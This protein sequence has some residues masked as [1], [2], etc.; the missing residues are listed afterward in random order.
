MAQA[1]PRE[2]PAVALRSHINHLRAL[3]AAATLALVGLT[4]AVAILATDGERDISGSS[5]NPLCALTPKERHR[6]QA[7]RS[8]SPGQP[9]AAFGRRIVPTPPRGTPYDGDPG[10]FGPPP[11]TPY[12]GDPGIFGPPPNRPYDGDPG[13]FR[14]PPNRPHDGDWGCLPAAPQR[15]GFATEMKDEA[16]TS[17]ALA[18]SSGGAEFGGSNVRGRHLSGTASAGRSPID[19]GH[20]VMFLGAPSRPP[21]TP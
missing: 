10:I 2:Q 13:I 16:G 9:T 4:A 3:L 11:N 17:V 8:L 15:A 7:L 14:P 21:L 6:V 18:Q 1:T 12:D 19:P 20:T 5:E